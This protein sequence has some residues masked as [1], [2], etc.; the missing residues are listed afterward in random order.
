VPVPRGARDMPKTLIEVL[1]GPD[2]VPKGLWEMT[3]EELAIACKTADVRAAHESS[4]VLLPTKI[5]GASQR[6]FG[7]LRDEFRVK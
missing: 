2:P 4:P 6:G 7:F 1:C 5:K 3:D